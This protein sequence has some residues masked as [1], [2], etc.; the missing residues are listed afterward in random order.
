MQTSSPITFQIND[1]S[2][3]SPSAM[4]SNLLGRF[5][6]PFISK[7]ATQTKNANNAFV[8][9]GIVG[10]NPP[11]GKD[12]EG[13]SFTP[14]RVSFNT[15]KYD[16]AIY[17]YRLNYD[18]FSA[19]M[20]NPYLSRSTNRPSTV[21]LGQAALIGYG[22]DHDTGT[23]LDLENIT[24]IYGNKR[25]DF[26][27]VLSDFRTEPEYRSDP[28]IAILPVIDEAANIR[29]SGIQ[30]RLFNA[31]LDPTPGHRNAYPVDPDFQVFGGA[32]F[33]LN[34]IRSGIMSDSDG[35][36]EITTSLNGSANESKD[37]GSAY[38]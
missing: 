20:M 1:P 4:A 2:Q 31:A 17:N 3:E 35:N 29:N 23:I 30:I 26:L 37:Q 28:S 33:A 24:S 8:A 38:E 7:M 34:N 9:S 14:C 21:S 5:F 13:G 16:L 27:G 10:D 18:F 32:Q 11:D 6:S 22:E 36:S 25:F 19:Y 12:G 15:G